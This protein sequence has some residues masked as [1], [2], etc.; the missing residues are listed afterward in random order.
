MQH[1]RVEDAVEREDAQSLEML[2]TFPFEIDSFFGA[3][4]K[5]EFAFKWQFLAV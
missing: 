3:G 5:T 2:L 4:Q 1:A